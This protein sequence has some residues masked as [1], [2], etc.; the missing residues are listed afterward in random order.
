MSSTHMH[1][2]CRICWHAHT[3]HV[4]GDTANFACTQRSCSCRICRCACCEVALLRVPAWQPSPVVV[5]AIGATVGALLM[6][7]ILA[8]LL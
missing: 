8:Q 6:L 7:V 5:F 4:P 3:H 2:T 1:N